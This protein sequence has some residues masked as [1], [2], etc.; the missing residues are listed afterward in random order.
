MMIRALV[1]TAALSGLLSPALTGVTLSGK[2][3]FEPNRGQ[4]RPDVL[5]GFRPSVWLG[6]DRFGLGTGGISVVLDGANRSPRVVPSD[7][8]PGVANVYQGSDS[9]RWIT[10]IP[11]YG[12]VTYRSVFPG[13]DLV[14]GSTAI[15]LSRS[16][17]FTFRFVVNPGADISPIQLAVNGATGNASGQLLILRT[18]SGILL[19][20]E[21][22]S[23]TAYQEATGSNVPAQ[24]VPGTSRPGHR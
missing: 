24:R 20:M 23:V 5:Y 7:T 17:R 3:G 16:F 8:L 22:L 13:I 10:N 21:T 4:F 6:A 12:P 14:F 18:G 2:A 9:R 15:E 11:R 19:R 1:L